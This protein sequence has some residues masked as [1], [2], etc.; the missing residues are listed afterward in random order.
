MEINDKIGRN[1]PCL[2][3][4][5]RKHKKCCLGKTVQ[6]RG[7]RIIVEERLEDLDRLKM[8]EEKV[9]NK[10]KVVHLRQKQDEIKGTI[11]PGSI[12]LMNVAYEMDEDD[13]EN[14][15]LASMPECTVE[16]AILGR[17]EDGDLGLSWDFCFEHPGFFTIDATYQ[18]MV[19][20]TGHGNIDVDQLGRETAF[21][22]LSEFSLLI[23][24]LSRAST[25]LPYVLGPIELLG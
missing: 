20:I 23:S 11:I 13:D 16:M 21:P 4:S 10:A 18:A 2:W 19:E 24:T 8:E 15:F 1:D 22:I 12:A 14:E 3:G 17:D 7:D 5:G 6:D 9:K 25:G